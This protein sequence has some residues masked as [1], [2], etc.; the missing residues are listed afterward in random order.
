MITA[1]KIR[2]FQ[3]GCSIA[4]LLAAATFLPTEAKAGDAVFFISGVPINAYVTSLQEK[5]F[6]TI[7]RQQYDFSCG[8]AALATLL[9]Y[10][11]DRP[12]TEAET[13]DEMWA[14]GNKAKIR[15]EGF[16]LLDMKKYLD[17]IGLRADGFK[18]P[19]D[20]LR[21]VGV[22]VITLITTRGY[23]HFVVLRGI[24][25]EHVVIGDPSLGSR[26]MKREDFME[27]WSGVAFAIHNKA[28]LA[29]SMFN[30]ERDMPHERRANL[31]LAVAINRLGLDGIT[32]LTPRI[33]AP[34]TIVQE[35]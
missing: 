10:H 3:A 14:V 33:V 9:T 23:T 32:I 29:R 15:K 12:T 6:E 18:L 26:L 17:T 35:F 1:R 7:V 22:P 30:L 21:E 5:K 24:T 16:S 11:Y 31:G 20:K 8:S 13:F 25:D 27:E 34:G 28:R 4:A 2:K 19:L